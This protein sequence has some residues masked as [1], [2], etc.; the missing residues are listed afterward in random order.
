MKVA[1]EWILFT[2]GGRAPGIGTVSGSSTTQT[3]EDTRGKR[4]TVCGARVHHIR[5][6]SRGK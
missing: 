4:E 3:A 6:G 2:G 1:Y 5:N